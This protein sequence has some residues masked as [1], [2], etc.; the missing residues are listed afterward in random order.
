MRRQEDAQPVDPNVRA[1][2]IKSV[3]HY[4]LKIAFTSGCSQGIF[5]YPYLYQIGEQASWR[6]SL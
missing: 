6:E 5:S 4:G 3:G 2:F 1:K